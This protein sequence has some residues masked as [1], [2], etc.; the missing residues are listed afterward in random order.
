MNEEP[1]IVIKLNGKFG[2]TFLTES[3]KLVRCHS[4][5]EAEDTLEKHKGLFDYGIW[6]PEIIIAD[7]ISEKD[8]FIEVK[9]SVIHN[10]MLQGKTCK[11]RDFVPIDGYG[12]K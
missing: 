2:N 3:G 6:A 10:P 9:A 1:M 11:L 5:S 4:I 12:G 8:G 7:S